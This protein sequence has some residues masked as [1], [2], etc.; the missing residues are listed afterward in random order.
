MVP[1]FTISLIAAFG[2]H[3]LLIF[4]PAI[5]EARVNLPNVVAKLL[6]SFLLGAPRLWTPSPPPL[7]YAT[8]LYRD[9]FQ[10]SRPGVPFEPNEIP[11]HW[12]W[13]YKMKLLCIGDYCEVC[14]AVLYT[15]SYYTINSKGILLIQ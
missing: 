14:C 6:W 8:G 11:I 4:G 7:S 1:F 9:K 15:Q 10:T 13:P 3:Q 12:G 5:T 2:R